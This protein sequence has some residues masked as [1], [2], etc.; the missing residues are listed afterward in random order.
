MLQRTHPRLTLFQ[1]QAN[2]IE[3]QLLLRFF[4]ELFGAPVINQI[5]QARFLTVG[6]IPMFDKDANHGRSH[7]H[8][9]RR[10]D[11]QS[12]IRSKLLVSG[13]PT[14]LHAEVNTGLHAL[15][16]ADAYGIKRDV[17]GIRTNGYAAAIIVS[18]IKFSR[19]TVE[20]AVVQN[21]LMHRLGIRQH[22]QHFF[23]VKA[24]GRAGCHIAQIIRPR[25]AGS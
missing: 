15:T 8:C 19:Q 2:Q 13:D 10:F 7:W 25:S 6:A 1:R 14:Q 20:V 11:Q 17:I 22:V 23:G 3:G 12:A 5:L 21:S 9:L 16:F 18:D 4:Q 24:T